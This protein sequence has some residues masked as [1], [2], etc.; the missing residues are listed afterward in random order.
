MERLKLET[1][2]EKGTSRGYRNVCKSREIGTDSMESQKQLP[3]M[4]KGKSEEHQSLHSI[5]SILVS[6][7]FGSWPWSGSHNS[8]EGNTSK[9][10]SM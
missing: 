1:V 10:I 2:T 8:T 5:S 6:T 7:D 9:L 4:V 3:A